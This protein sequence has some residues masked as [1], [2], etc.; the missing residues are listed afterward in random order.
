MRIF[1]FNS[2][3]YIQRAKQW[4]ML[5]KGKGGFTVVTQEKKKKENNNKSV[6]KIKTDYSFCVV[7]TVGVTA[8]HD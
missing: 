1:F 4:K 5:R 7:L 8:L 6:N 3:C 2:T